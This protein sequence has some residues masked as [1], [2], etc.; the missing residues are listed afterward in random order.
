CLN[1]RRQDILSALVTIQVAE[2]IDLFVD[3]YSP[4][5]GFQRRSPRLVAGALTAGEQDN[6]THSRCQTGE[7]ADRHRCSPFM[8]QESSGSYTTCS[9]LPRVEG[10]ERLPFQDRNS[11]PSPRWPRQ[12]SPPPGRLTLPVVI[13]TFP[14]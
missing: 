14:A 11:T 4:G 2:Q 5:G 3:G 12:T 7:D 9:P 10:E 1:G 13:R 6:K 8:G